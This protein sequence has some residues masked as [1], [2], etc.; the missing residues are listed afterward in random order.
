MGDVGTG[1]AVKRPATGPGSRRYLA[2]NLRIARTL[3]GWSQEKLALRCGL[4]RTYIGTLERAE[5]NPGIDNVDR[6]AAGLGVP[7][8]VLLLPPDMA[9]PLIHAHLDSA[10]D[11][12]P[13]QAPPSMA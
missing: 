10:L 11:T 9:Q 5:V 4:K 6:I 2:Q 8:H 13:A 7:P 12:P 1:A 3:G